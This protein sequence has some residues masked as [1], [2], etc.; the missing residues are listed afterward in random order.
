ME[1]TLKRLI[2]FRNERNWEQFH[3]PE[4]LA[5]T[6]VIES[7]KLLE[8]FQWKDKCKNKEIACKKIADIIC[9][10]LLLSDSLNVDITKIIND[11]IANDEKEYPKIKHRKTLSSKR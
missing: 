3:E 5:K 10:C 1:N 2:E 8:Q 6:I 9:D 4:T 11:K 7:S